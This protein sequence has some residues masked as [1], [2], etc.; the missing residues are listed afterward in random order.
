MLI[1]ATTSF[2]LIHSQSFLNSEAEFK[3][4]EPRLKFKPGLKY[5][6]FFFKLYSIVQDLSGRSIE[7]GFWGFET[8]LKFIKFGHRSIKNIS[9]ALNT[10]AR[11]AI[12][13]K[14]PKQSIKR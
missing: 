1:K 11:S 4:F 12:T 8:R 13:R 9:I 5:G 10:I 3:E 7:T 6:W 2:I 14:L